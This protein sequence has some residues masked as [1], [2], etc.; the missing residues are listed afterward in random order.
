MC[1]SIQEGRGQAASKGIQAG[2]PV[3]IEYYYALAPGAKS[4]WLALYKKNHNPILMQLMK[5]G[6]LTSKKLY[7]RRFHAQSPA[8]DYKVVL[9]W[10]DWA[11]LAEGQARE[12]E[13][14]RKLYPNQKEHE[15]QE[16][17]RWELTAAH[18]DDVLSEIPLE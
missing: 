14:I 13:I 7:E 11:A 8:W 10:R 2:P 6:L 3:V 12:S 17:R 1:L 15:R 18:W 9:T 16:K 4:E 5:D